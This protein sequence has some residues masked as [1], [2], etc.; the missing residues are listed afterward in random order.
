MLRAQN[1]VKLGDISPISKNFA[2]NCP[3]SEK[4]HGKEKKKILFVYI[5]IKLLV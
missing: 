4:A 2:L 5:F 1:K 3:E